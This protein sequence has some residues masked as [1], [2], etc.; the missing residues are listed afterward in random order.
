VTLPATG[1]LADGQLTRVEAEAITLKTAQPVSF[2][3]EKFTWDYAVEPTTDH[4]YVNQGYGIVD[5]DSKAR[6]LEVLLGEIPMPVRTDADAWI[7]QMDAIRWTIY[8]SP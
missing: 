3:A 7:A 2:D 4:Y 1:P 8:G 5:R 6:A